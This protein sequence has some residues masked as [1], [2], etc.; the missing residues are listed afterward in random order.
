MSKLGTISLE[1][2][3]FFA[4]HGF[5]PEERKIGNKYTVD[6]FVKADIINAAKDDDLN[7][8]VNYEQLY[9]IVKSEMEQSTKLL[10]SLVYRMAHRILKE[11]DAVY[12][13]EVQLSKHNPP[14]GGVCARSKLRQTLTRNDL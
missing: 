3:E 11:L 4:Y 6:L 1:A 12:E 8:T 14:I 7:L 5:Y 9:A 13:V 2:M 10:E